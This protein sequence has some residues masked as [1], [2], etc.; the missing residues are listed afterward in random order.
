MEDGG[1]HKLTYDEALRETREMAEFATQLP[2]WFTAS[3]LAI[4]TSSMSSPYSRLS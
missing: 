4:V 3:T 2:Q 1:D